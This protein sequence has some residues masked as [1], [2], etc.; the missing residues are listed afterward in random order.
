MVISSVL[1]DAFACTLYN[2]L[3]CTLR[4]IGVVCDQSIVSPASSAEDNVNFAVNVDVVSF[5]E[6]E[7]YLIS[8]TFHSISSE[9]TELASTIW[10]LRSAKHIAAV[11]EFCCF[12][13]NYW[14]ISVLSGELIPYQDSKSGRT[15]TER[16]KVLAI[17]ALD[18][19]PIVCSFCWVN[20][21]HRIGS[22]RKK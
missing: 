10:V 1:S 20:Y 3:T 14:G 12:V 15:T 4:Y 18:R 11:G 19:G 2:T 22:C 7:H 8:T 21:G 13:D 16:K 6:P 5:D 9:N 17:G